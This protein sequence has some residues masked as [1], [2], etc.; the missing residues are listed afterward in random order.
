MPF[1]FCCYCKRC[2]EDNWE[3]LWH[4]QHR[5]CLKHK[6]VAGCK[7]EGDDGIPPTNKLVGILPKIL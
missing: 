4:E 1:S 5:Q 7:A 3:R 6:E 2:F